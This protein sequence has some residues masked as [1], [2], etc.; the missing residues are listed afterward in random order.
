MIR[1]KSPGLRLEKYT[2]TQKEEEVLEGDN[3]L[4]GILFL[5]EEEEA[6]VEEES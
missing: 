5:E 1:H 3:M 4:E 6:K 2:I